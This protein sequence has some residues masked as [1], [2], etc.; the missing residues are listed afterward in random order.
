MAII[1]MELKVSRIYMQG[2]LLNSREE[3]ELVGVTYWKREKSKTNRLICDLTRI[4]KI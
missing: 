4:W 1:D 2:L 3:I